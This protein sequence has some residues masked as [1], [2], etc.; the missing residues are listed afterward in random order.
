MVRVKGR[1]QVIHIY[2]LIAPADAR[3]TSAHDEALAVYAEA[4]ETY[5]KGMWTEAIGLFQQTL[6]LRANDGPARVLS[7]RC[8]EYRDEPPEPWDGVYEQLI[9]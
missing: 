4:L 8:L 2:E 5:R 6:R 3:L 1:S 9:K 7:R